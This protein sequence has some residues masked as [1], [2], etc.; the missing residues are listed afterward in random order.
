MQEAIKLTDLNLRKLAKSAGHNLLLKGN[1]HLRENL[2][3]IEFALGIETAAF[4]AFSDKK[5]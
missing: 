2:K 1:K 3:H 5:L 4:L